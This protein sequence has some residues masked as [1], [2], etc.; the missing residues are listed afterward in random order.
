[1]YLEAHQRNDVPLNQVTQGWHIN[2]LHTSLAL[3]QARIA[4]C[5]QAGDEIYEYT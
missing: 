4:Q 1:L 3:A 5:N 2:T